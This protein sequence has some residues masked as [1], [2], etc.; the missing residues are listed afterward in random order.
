M[1]LPHLLIITVCC[2]ILGAP[3]AHAETRTGLVGGLGL[4]LGRGHNGAFGTM[5]DLHLGVMVS[6]SLAIIA[7]VGGLLVATGAA[8]T[9]GSQE[10]QLQS[11]TMYG[12]GGKFWQSQQVWLKATVGAGQDAG[13]EK[14]GFAT[15][16]AIGYQLSQDGA[17]NL[18]MR[19]SL[20]VFSEGTL[21]DYG[22]LLGLH[23]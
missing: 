10:D 11:L 5:T 7:E 14:T 19:A 13:T 9:N 16:T 3:A 2:L 22:L 12:V 21:A 6:P 4:G 18:A 15:S 20:G 23:W 1:K 8:E 17:F